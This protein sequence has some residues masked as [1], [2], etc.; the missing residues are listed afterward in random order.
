MA[1]TI[2]AAVAEHFGDGPSPTASELFLN[3]NIQRG[4]FGSEH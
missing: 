1:L 3:A 4:Q 2:Q